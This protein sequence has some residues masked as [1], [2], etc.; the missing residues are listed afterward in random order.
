MQRSAFPTN[1]WV[2]NILY[3]ENLLIYLRK[4]VVLNPCKKSE[5][6]TVSDFLIIYSNRYMT[7]KLKEKA[8][9]ESIRICRAYVKLHNGIFIFGGGI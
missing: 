9:A 8:E 2:L 6:K 3:G 1:V 7:G 5:T 4:A